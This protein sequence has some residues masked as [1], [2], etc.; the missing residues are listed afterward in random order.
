[1]PKFCKYSQ[2]WGPEV[3]KSTTG[4]LDILLNI[5]LE[6]TTKIYVEAGV[7]IIIESMHEVK[8]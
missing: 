6:K 7:G 8:E 4:V 1:M 5:E 2:T 3:T